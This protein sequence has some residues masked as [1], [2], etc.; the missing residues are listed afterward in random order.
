MFGLSGYKPAARKRQRIVNCFGYTCL[1]NQ[2]IQTVLEIVSIAGDKALDFY[3]QDVQ[4]EHKSNTHYS[5][6]VSVADREV[7]KEIRKH[8]EEHFPDDGI[9]GEEGE[10]KISKSNRLWLLDPIDGTSPFLC[11]RN[12]SWA[13]VITLLTGNLSGRKIEVRDHFKEEVE[14][15]LV[16]IYLPAEKQF[17]FA[18][19]TGAYFWEGDLK[20]MPSDL[21]KLSLSG[22]PTQ[23][24]HS[25]ISSYISSKTREQDF[26][27]SI[28]LFKNSV[29]VFNGSALASESGQVARGLVD[30]WALPFPEHCC[31][32]DYLPGEFIVNQAGGTNLVYGNWH[33]VA[34]NIA[35][36]EEIQALIKENS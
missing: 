33:I 16:V 36:A 20:D 12:S 31:P 10:D 23:L 21:A 18:D 1:M 17:V 29:L 35:L 5:D 32:W 28:A 14:T 11:K 7:E 6:P 13:V 25:M 22:E 24:K 15:I 30:A 26:P 4:V 9:I 2:E 8:L 34:T 27:A 19:S 3:Q